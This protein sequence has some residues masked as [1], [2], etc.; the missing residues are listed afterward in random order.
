M[1]RILSMPSIS[2]SASR[3]RGKGSAK[4]RGVPRLVAHAVAQ[5]ALSVKAYLRA[6]VGRQR[7]R[8]G[9]DFARRARIL[10]AAHVGDDAVAAAVVASGEYGGE[11]LERAGGM[12]RKRL[13]HPFFAGFEARKAPFGEDARH[14]AERARADGEVEPLHALEHFLAQPLHRATGKPL[15]LRL[16]AH[17]AAVDDHDVGVRLACGLFV[18][19]G[20][21]HRLERFAVAHVHLAAVRMD[22]ELQD[23]LRFFFER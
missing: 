16:L 8:F 15:L 2:D 14:E 20:Q 6:A 11:R 22:V 17:R 21:Q 9:D 19:G 18:P 7:A 3:R 10:V 13:R 4:P 12:R 5:H 23:A 1:K